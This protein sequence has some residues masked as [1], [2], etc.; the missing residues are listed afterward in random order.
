[1]AT[2]STA[3]N[4]AID[5]LLFDLDGT[6][7]DTARDFEYV[8]N[9]QLAEHGRKPIDYQRLRGVVSSGARAMVSL[10]FG[11]DEE[12]PEFDTLKQQFLTLYGN[13]LCSASRLFPGMSEVIDWAQ[14]EA[15]PMAIVTNKPSTF[16]LPLMDK[17]KLS[18]YFASIVCP[19][20]VTHAKPHPEPILLAC[21]QLNVTPHR[22]LYIGDHLRD[23]EAGRH[24]AM[25]TV[26]CRYGYIADGEQVED[27]QPDFI[28]DA[29][30]QL[31]AL[32]QSIA[33][34]A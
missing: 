19:D 28:I 15:I 21:K 2:S 11:I 8:L 3:I 18:Q 14:R 34:K 29:A 32:C 33:D 22:C 10:G 5:A 26:A 25:A 12:H 1:M 16:T 31:I 13:Y 7:L 24:A 4:S 30:D 20:H 27:W 17:L 23:I 6:V 9:L